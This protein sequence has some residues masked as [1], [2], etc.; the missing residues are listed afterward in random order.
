MYEIYLLV[1][2]ILLPPAVFILS[3]ALLSWTLP[4]RPVLM[5][6]LLLLLFFTFY[7]ASTSAFGKLLA[8]TLISHAAL[9][10][11]VASSQCAAIVVL[12]GGLYPAAPEYGEDTASATT[13][14]R[15]RYGARLYR[16]TGRP[17][18]VSGGRPRRTELSE[19]D[20]MKKI[21][22][23]EFSI[24]VRWI[25]DRSRNTLEAARNSRAI[26]A[27]EN[28]RK[29]CLVTHILHMARAAEVFR[30]EGFDVVA[31]PTSVGAYE[32]FVARDFVPS[33]S[34]LGLTGYVL[35]EWLGRAWYAVRSL[36]GA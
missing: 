8:G 34:G 10:P 35:H 22:E 5:R 27:G 11:P 12:G 18:L 16:D 36:I 2:Q 20:V 32:R 14:V 23:T 3:G 13:L 15:L 17:I 4:K 31:A 30:R 21:L 26:L 1:K 19:A 7:L 24:P 33:T 25:E 29:I 9:P 6:R 28:V